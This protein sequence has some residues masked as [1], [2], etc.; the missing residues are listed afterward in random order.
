MNDNDND[1]DTQRSPASIEWRPGLTGKSVGTMAPQKKSV[2]L[3][4]LTR[5]QGAQVQTAKRQNVVQRYL[6]WTQVQRERKSNMNHRQLLCWIREL[7]TESSDS[8]Q[9]H[10]QNTMNT[11]SPE[12]RG[13]NQETRR[14][15]GTREE[16]GRIPQYSSRT[17]CWSQI[18]FFRTISNRTPD[19][20]FIWEPVTYFLIVSVRVHLALDRCTAAA[21]AFTMLLIAVLLLLCSRT[22]LQIS[23]CYFTHCLVYFSSSRVHSFW[24]LA[25]LIQVLLF[26]F[27]L[28]S[29]S[30]I[31]L[32]SKFCS[33]KTLMSSSHLFFG[34]PIVLLVLENSNNYLSEDQKLS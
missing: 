20:S 7:F 33:K 18:L 24:S 23:F 29:G 14:T 2:L 15:K 19:I 31:F 12:A 4:E 27:F 16:D 1:N 9:H 34:L 22:T 28:S 5:R 17:C 11:G 25:I 32:S 3:V 8:E 13:G 30:S 10:G 21:F 26:W 6:K